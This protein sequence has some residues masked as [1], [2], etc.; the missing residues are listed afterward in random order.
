[1]LHKINGNKWCLC[2]LAWHMPK[3]DA[4]H[5]FY[6]YD[7]WLAC[8]SFWVHYYYVFLSLTTSTTAASTNNIPQCPTVQR[9][10]GVSFCFIL[11]LFLSQAC[12]TITNKMGWPG[13]AETHVNTFGV[14]SSS[15]SR[16][17]AVLC[18]WISSPISL[19][20]SGDCLCFVPVAGSNSKPQ[21]SAHPY[22]CCHVIVCPAPHILKS[23]LCL[24]AGPCL[25]VALFL[26]MHSGECLYFVPIVTSCW[27]EFQLH[28]CCASPGCWPLFITLASSPC[29]PAQIVVCLVQIVTIM[30]HFECTNRVTLSK[31]SL[32][33]LSA[34]VC[35][36]LLL[37]HCLSYVYLGPSHDLW[38]SVCCFHPSWPVSY[39][40]VKKICQVVYCDNCNKIIL[41]DILQSDACTAG[42][43]SDSMPPDTMSAPT[44]FP[45]TADGHGVMTQL[46]R[47]K[48]CCW[49]VNHQAMVWVTIQLTHGHSHNT[50]LQCIITPTP[51]INS[52]QDWHFFIASLHYNSK[53]SVE[54]CTALTEKV[55]KYLV[56]PMPPEE[57]LKTFFPLDKISQETEAEVF[58]VGCYKDTVQA[59]KERLAYGP[60]VS[61]LNGRPQPAL[62]I[63]LDFK[64]KTTETFMPGFSAVDS[65]NYPDC[66]Q[67]SKFPFK[68]KPDISVYASC[69]PSYPTELVSVEIFIEFKWNNTND[70]FCDDTQETFTHPSKNA[71]DTLGQITSYVVLHLATQFRTHIYSILII[72]CLARILHWDRLGMIMME[73]F[74]YDQCPYL[75]EF[76]CWYSRA[77]DDMCGKDGTVSMPTYAKECTARC[78]LALTHKPDVPLHKLAIIP[79]DKDPLYFI[80]PPPI[81]TLYA[82]PGR[83]T[84]SFEAYD[85]AT[86]QVVFLKDS[87]RIMLPGIKPEGLVYA[88]LNSAN[89]CWTPNCLAWEDI[90]DPYHITQTQNFTQAKWARTL[91]DALNNSLNKHQ[92]LCHQHTC[93]ILN[94][95][96][97][98]L[99]EYQSSFEMVST[100]RN[101]LIGEGSKATA[102]PCDNNVTLFSP[103][104]C[105][106]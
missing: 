106:Y 99:L 10:H 105:L 69:K 77:P 76:F 95:I 47:A 12:H 91:N 21:L 9:M 40:I 71:D 3:A 28:C 86:S 15:H 84:C 29:S 46:V 61:P 56:G 54:S 82:P 1:M 62:T 66:H 102:G 74:E 88:K 23:L 32:L 16:I 14:V 37:V 13:D 25:W 97:S 81:L 33:S 2:A 72:R 63:R 89:V 31:L 55:K 7:L 44:L 18:H 42:W 27:L 41:L 60:F 53:I 79:L 70:P 50:P 87:W 98:T 104:W 83:A 30:D 17:T 49:C 35:I 11:F 48:A 43:N 75:A 24:A 6:M 45:A 59:V 26:S 64:I 73:A 4:S 51:T 85:I 8:T 22:S 94:V 20:H 67:S 36:A 92:F 100:V 90:L 101:G 68:V 5:G 57:F 96:G 19:L 34:L 65:S 58:K 52:S 103:G 39:I 38:C 78:A 93:L 80:T